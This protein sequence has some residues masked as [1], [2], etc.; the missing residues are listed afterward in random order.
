MAG[1]K[2]KSRIRFFRYFLLT[3]CFLLIIVNP[4]LNYKWDI[5]FVQGWFQ[6]LGIGNMWIVSPLEG[7]ETILTGKFFYLPSIIG[8]LIP[9][10]LAF[11]LGRVFCSWMCP[12]TFLSML[13]D[14][15]LGLIPVFGKK[16]KYRRG[17]ILLNRRVIWFALLGELILTMVIGYPLFVWWSPPGL[18]GRETMFYVFYHVITVEIFIVIAV[19]LLNLITRRFFCRYL[20]PLGALLALV[21]SKRQLVIKYDAD[22]CLS[23]RICDTRCPLGIKPSVGESQSIYCWN[24]AECV[25]A[26]PTNALSF[27]W[28]SDGIVRVEKKSLLSSQ[29]R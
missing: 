13:T 3:V 18:V 26:C 16:L 12:I 17:L 27:T 29:A 4:I 20:C 14:K 15:L 1:V 22:K 10:L 21:A 2:K 24:C 8:M 23:C 6:S 9:L 28:R 7:L 19:L 25:D 5:N 11:L